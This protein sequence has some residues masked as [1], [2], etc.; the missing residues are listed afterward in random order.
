MTSGK[1]HVGVS[2]TAGA[3]IIIAI[4]VIVGAG[5]YFGMQPPTPRST[6]ACLSEAPESTCSSSTM[7]PIKTT[8][9]STSCVNEAPGGGSGALGCTSTSTVT[10]TPTL[11]SSAS[12]AST[13][14]ASASVTIP[15][16][17]GVGASA[18]PGYT[19][20]TI[21]V[22]I[23]V[24]NT[25][26]WTNSDTVNHTVYS[27]SV[28]T[29]ASAFNSPMITPGGTYTQTFTVPGTYSYHCNIH[30]WMTG[31]VIVKSG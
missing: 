22:V 20:D 6:T 29:G 11:S 21:T 9:T 23:G 16:G 12:S 31:T 14:G 4:L 10:R 15:S 24:N 28:P 8:S 1:R 17:A 7:P 2:T 13:R 27:T 19:P 30:S 26:T 18:A 5:V 25:V 3:A